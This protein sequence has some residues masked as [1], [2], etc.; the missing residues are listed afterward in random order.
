MREAPA[1][2]A[3]EAV[4]IGVLEEGMMLQS[5]ASEAM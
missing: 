1:M 5:C 4:V 2:N 3:L